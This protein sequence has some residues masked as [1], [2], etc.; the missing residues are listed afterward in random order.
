MVDL[1]FLQSTNAQEEIGTTP[2]RPIVI[3]DEPP[4]RSRRVSYSWSTLCLD[5]FLQLLITLFFE[6][7]NILNIAD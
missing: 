5:I 7:T 2:S 3:E 1:F 4:P 6:S